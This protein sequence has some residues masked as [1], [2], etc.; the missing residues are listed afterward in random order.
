VR[1]QN[2]R[3]SRPARGGGMRGGRGGRR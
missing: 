3:A 2:A 1:A